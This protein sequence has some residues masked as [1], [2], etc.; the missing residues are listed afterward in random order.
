M[1]IFFR[2]P[3]V[4]CCKTFFTCSLQPQ[5]NSSI[6]IVNF[7]PSLIFVVIVKY[8]FTKYHL[9]DIIL[10]VS[11]YRLS[12]IR[13]FYKMPF[14]ISFYKLSFNISLYKMS[15]KIAFYKTT[16]YKVSL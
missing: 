8:N 3:R 4:Q 15:F 13:S 11:F 5:I 9:K 14:K 2:K 16:F 6:L 10:I 12:N 7:N 1:K